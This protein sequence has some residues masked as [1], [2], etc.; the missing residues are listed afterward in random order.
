MGTAG[1]IGAGRVSL[2]ARRLEHACRGQ[3]PEAAASLIA[4]LRAAESETAAAMR[5]WMAV[6]DTAA[7]AQSA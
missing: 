3:E 7:A 1:N 2:I 4:L 5:A 6:S